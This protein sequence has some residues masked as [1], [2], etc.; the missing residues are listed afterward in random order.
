VRTGL[1][2]AELNRSLITGTKFATVEVDPEDRSVFAWDAQK[3]A[4]I[5]STLLLCNSF[6]EDLGWP[7][8]S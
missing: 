2:Q 1:G 3:E 7:A 4:L 5:P 6:K 8:F